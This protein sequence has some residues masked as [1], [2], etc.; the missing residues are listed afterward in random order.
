M[1]KLPRN[2]RLSDSKP[3]AK[4]NWKFPCGHLR[5]WPTEAPTQLPFHHSANQ[6]NSLCIRSP[7][8][9]EQRRRPCS[10]ALRKRRRGWLPINSMTPSTPTTQAAF[11]QAYWLAQPP[12]V[13]ALQSIS[14]FQTR[15]ATAMQLATQG[16]T[17]DVPIMVWGWDPYLVMSQ[18]QQY[19]YTWVP[20]A[21]MAPVTMAPGV[22]QPGAIGYDP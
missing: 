20:S 10:R 6:F 17:V 19:G 15:L 22:T 4:G 18:R 14:D 8:T 3:A 21:L 12:A 16:Y 5:R 1:Y 13:Q 11:D 9:N 7:A 2:H